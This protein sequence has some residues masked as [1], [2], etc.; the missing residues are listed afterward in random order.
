MKVARIREAIFKALVL[1]VMGW[2]FLGLK[3][4]KKLIGEQLLPIINCLS[5][6]LA[7]VLN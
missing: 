3:K 2:C 7:Q 6:K 1:E 5:R 4:D